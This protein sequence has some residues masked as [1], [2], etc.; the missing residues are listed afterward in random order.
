MRQANPHDAPGMWAEAAHLLRL[1]GP[2][3]C[4]LPP[5]MRGMSLG[6]IEAR[7]REEA[8]ERARREAADAA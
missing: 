3:K 4:V 5:Q 6:E 1:Y 2:H 7:A 8:E